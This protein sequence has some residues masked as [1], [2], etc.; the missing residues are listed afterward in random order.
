MYDVSKPTKL[1]LVREVVDGTSGSFQRLE[2]KSRIMTARDNLKLW[3]TEF[4]SDICD[5]MPMCDNS[6]GKTYRH[7]PSWFTRDIVLKE[8]EIEMES[9]HQGKFLFL[10]NS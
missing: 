6:Y 1:R 5:I 9:R 7:L 4:F 3:L 2:K 10:L 8:Y